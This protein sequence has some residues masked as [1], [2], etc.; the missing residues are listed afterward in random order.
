VIQP[1]GTGTST[2]YQPNNAANNAGPAGPSIN[3]PAG[4]K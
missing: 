4:T 1:V 2:T 3:Q